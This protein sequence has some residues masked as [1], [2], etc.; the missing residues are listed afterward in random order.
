MSPQL[1][2]KMHVQIEE[3]L[4]LDNDTFE[5]YKVL[6]SIWLQYPGQHAVDTDTVT[7]THNLTVR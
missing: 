3:I 7:L 6:W 5:K 2:F 1:T 4:A